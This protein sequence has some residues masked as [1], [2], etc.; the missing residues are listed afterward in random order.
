MYSL[1]KLVEKT[2]DTLCEVCPFR[3]HSLGKLVE[4]EHGLAYA[5]Y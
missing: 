4:K 5:E 1:G 3:M 2:T